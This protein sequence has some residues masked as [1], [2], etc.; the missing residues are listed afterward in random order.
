MVR[1][2]TIKF[3]H[4]R[5]AQ[6]LNKRIDAEEATE[7]EVLRFALSLVA[8]WDFVDADT[9]KPLS[10]DELDELS[11]DQCKEVNQLFAQ[12]M[13]VT[14]EIPKASGGNSPSTSTPLNQVESPETSPT[15]YI[16]LYSPENSE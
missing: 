3:K 14:A 10:I 15:G 13:G 1:F 16:P 11:M 6:E 7:E 12:K 2:K 4:Y 9:G 8:E 5:Q